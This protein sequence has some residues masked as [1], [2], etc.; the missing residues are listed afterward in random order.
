MSPA[1]SES[2]LAAQD[3]L[4]HARHRPDDPFDDLDLLDEVDHDEFA[5]HVVELMES[6]APT[7]PEVVRAV[8][9]VVA[10][11][12]ASLEPDAGAFLDG[13]GRVVLAHV[14]AGAERWDLALD[15]LDEAVAVEPG[16]AELVAADRDRVLAARAWAE[17][18]LAAAATHCAE[19]VARQEEA[20]AWGAAGEA[21]AQAA[22]VA[23]ARDDPEG[24]LAWWRRAADHFRQAGA[25]GPALECAGNGALVALRTMRALPDRDSARALGL[26]EQGRSLAADHGCERAAAELACSVG[27]FGA[28]AGRPWS[29]C[30]AAFEEARR[31][32]AADTTLVGADRDL[33][34]AWVDF[35]AGN[36][37]MLRSL[38]AEAEPF[39]RRAL[40]GY[41]RHGR[42][43]DA[44]R[45]IRLLQGV[46]GFV[47][48]GS[49]LAER[50]PVTTDDPEHEAVVLLAGAIS[51]ADGGRY[52]EAI[53]LLGGARERALVAGSPV[54]A[55]MVDLVDAVH[56]LRR[57][58]IDVA[59]RR[60]ADVDRLVDAGLDLPTTFR[61]GLDVLR[62]LLRGAL[63][64][65]DGEP[66]VLL[67]AL[68]TVEARSLAAGAGTRAAF[69]ATER[70]SVLARLGR[71][72]EALD[73]VLPAVLALD[74]YR[75]TLDDADRRRRW[76]RTVATAFGVAF[77]AAAACGATAVI[78]ELIEVARGNG[79]PIPH[80]EEAG[81]FESLVAEAGRSL[82]SEEDT[83]EGRDA[84]L[85][86]LDGALSVADGARRT[87]LG[88]PPRLLTPWGTVA[89]EAALDEAEGYHRPLRNDE[90][91][92]WRIT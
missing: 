65:H 50:I 7:E 86:P 74:A 27:V 42:T 90:V 70:A 87:V 85:A 67:E 11:F 80:T 43:A 40:D 72:R 31:R 25:S 61:D 5:G 92:A 3:V 39:L 60:L 66:Q 9:G 88:V 48:G 20:G 56:R 58:E 73:A 78:A 83:P 32:Y 17:G 44:Q 47:A 38:P 33:A 45:C 84:D 68:A 63:A 21:A 6:L 51:A 36:A 81:T 89:L 14:E 12:V 10:S 62:L 59:R 64:S 8:W 19:A 35:S 26:A 49:G 53:E 76:S 54:R 55:A 23:Q 28:D 46:V 2:A 91:R 41:T 52:D 16:L 71:H 24:A 29:D 18:D 34:P 30:V 13:G 69:A 77:R 75:F 57:G 15:L 4:D 82:L 37:A 22:A 79:A 1:P